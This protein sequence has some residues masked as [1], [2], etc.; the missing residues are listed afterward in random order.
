MPFSIVLLQLYTDCPG[1]FFNISEEVCLTL[2]FLNL[3][4]FNLSA[5]MLFAIALNKLIFIKYPLRYFRIV[6]LRRMVFLF[7]ICGALSLNTVAIVYLSQELSPFTG[8]TDECFRYSAFS[9]L[10]E[11]T[12]LSQSTSNSH[13]PYVGDG[14]RISCLSKHPDGILTF[15]LISIAIKQS[16][17]NRQV[18]ALAVPGRDHSNGDRASAAD[19]EHYRSK[20]RGL[21]NVVYLV[22]IAFLSLVM[23]LVITM[24]TH[25][26]QA[27]VNHN[28]ILFVTDLTIFLW[29]CK[30]GILIISDVKWRKAVKKHLNIKVLGK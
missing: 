26:Y 17:L 6:T 18:V 12:R 4:S 29:M 8:L 28:A 16:R 23:S 25:F 30:M 13:L 1:R 22:K 27:D 14:S 10:T 15:A 21:L 11:I 20:M 24:F 9:G 5:W 2:I 7:A 3:L 19:R